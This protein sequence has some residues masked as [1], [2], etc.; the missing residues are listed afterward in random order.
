MRRIL[1]TDPAARS[2]GV[3][4][5]TRPASET[6]DAGQLRELSSYRPPA[7]KERRR[8]LSQGDDFTLNRRK[9]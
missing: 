8:S 5:N 4:K 2:K 3:E 1:D 9:A 7:R 6:P